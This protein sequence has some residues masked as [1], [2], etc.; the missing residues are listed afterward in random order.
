MY[1]HIYNY[2]YVCTKSHVYSGYTNK[3]HKE[4]RE[5]EREREVVA[6]RD[7]DRAI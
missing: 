7:T 4:G 3:H 6:E 5:R 2:V 1:V